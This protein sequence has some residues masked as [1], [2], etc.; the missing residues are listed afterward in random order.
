MLEIICPDVQLNL[1]NNSHSQ[2][3]QK[4]FFK[5]NYRL[6]QVKS[7]AECS[8]G[9]ILQYFPPSLSYHLSLRPL[10]CLFLSGCFTVSYI[11]F[12]GYPNGFYCDFH[13]EYFI[14]QFYP[15]LSKPQYINFENSV[16]SD[17]LTSELI[18][19]HSVFH[20]ACKCMLIAR[21]LQENCIKIE[22]ECSTL[23]NNRP[24]LKSA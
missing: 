24:L 21:V 18:R 20:W 12:T 1:C 23:N 16:D 14:C 3:D 7:I 17:Q 11:F 2:K 8:K 9:S 22:E 19:I 5:T 4:L 15:Y 10:F 13:R 6:M